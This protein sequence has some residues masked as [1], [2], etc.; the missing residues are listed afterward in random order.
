[1]AAWETCVKRDCNTNALLVSFTVL[2]IL[3]L[4]Y[5]F[6]TGRLRH[7]NPYRHHADHGQLLLLT[8]MPPDSI[9]RCS[10][11]PEQVIKGELQQTPCPNTL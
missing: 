3:T 6:P 2:L 9:N 8:H 11:L 4:C 10:A 5:V 7:Y 1:M